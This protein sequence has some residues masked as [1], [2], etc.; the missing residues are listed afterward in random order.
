MSSN[1]Q[2]KAEY[3]DYI[4][5][6]ILLLV[7]TAVNITVAGFGHWGIISGIIVLISAIQAVITLIWFMHLDLDSKLMRIFVAGVF[8]LF[9][10]VTILTFFDYN[11][12]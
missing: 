10:I 9:I 8:L 3:T 4:K 1:S 5:I 12:R 2:H 6:A 11:F 7:L